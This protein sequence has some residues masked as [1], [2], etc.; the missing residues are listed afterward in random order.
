MFTFGVSGEKPL[1]H[2]GH[3]AFGGLNEVRKYLVALVMV[4]PGQVE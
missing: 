3:V 2:L 1:T 4:K